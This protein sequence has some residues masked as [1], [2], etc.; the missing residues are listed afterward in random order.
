MNKFLL[1][2]I[3]SRISYLTRILCNRSFV[4]YRNFNS[5]WYSFRNFFN[6]IRESNVLK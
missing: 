6:W 5:N 2:V 3:L 1:F 4:F